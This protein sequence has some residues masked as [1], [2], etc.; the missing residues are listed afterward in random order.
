MLTAQSGDAVILPAPYYFNHKMTLDMLGIEAI[1]L[2]CKADTNYAPDP[3]SAAKL[4]NDRVKAIVLVSP[5]NPTG[6]VY[7]PATIDAI[8]ELCGRHG[9]WLIIDETYRDFLPQSPPHHLFENK[10][11]ENLI[12]LYSFSKSLALPGYR[13]GAMI[14]P[15]KLAEA[16]VKVQDCVQICPARVG[17]IAATWALGGLDQWR[18]EKRKQLRLKAQAFATAMASCPGWEIESLGAYFA[19]LRHP[20][21]DIPAK[22]VAMRLARDNGLL[23]IPGS[24]F[25]EHQHRYLRVSFGNL[26]EETLATLPD[27][28]E[29]R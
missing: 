19:Y 27:R 23:L 28:F 13:L 20:F 21:S 6:A 25:G 15:A 17:Q 4:I 2:P 29:L 18:D 22:E 3:S 16:A 1:E 11:C 5:N 12:S 24:F 26:L 10:T 7:S 14:Y 9:I 8:S